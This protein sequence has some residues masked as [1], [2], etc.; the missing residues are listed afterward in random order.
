MEQDTSLHKFNNIIGN[1]FKN[2][3]FHGTDSPSP[4]VDPVNKINLNVA[5]ERSVVGDAH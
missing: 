4:V 5:R 3:G 1:G 2:A